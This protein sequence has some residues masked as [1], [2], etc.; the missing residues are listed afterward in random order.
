M[1]ESSSA[2]GSHA[3]YDPEKARSDVRQ[4]FSD[5]LRVGNEI[6]R[7]AANLLLRAFQSSEANLVDIVAIGH[8]YRSLIVAADGCLLCLEAGAAEQALVHTRGAFEASLQLQWLLKVDRETRA[9]RFYVGHL[10]EERSWHLR[11][12]SGT[13]EH[14]EHKKVWEAAGDSGPP[15]DPEENRVLVDRTNAELATDA[16]REVNEWFDTAKQRGGRSFE[17]KWYSVGP[18]GQRNLSS[19]ATE[20]GRRTDYRTIYKY[21]SYAVHSS[22]LT[23]SVGVR[24]SKMTIEHI[25]IPRHFSS[26]FSFAFTELLSRSLEIASI[27]RPDDVPQFVSRAHT[28]WLPT[29]SRWV[30]VKLSNASE[31]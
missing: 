13:A 11:A 27:Y 30:D 16:Y 7:E 17:P 2:L 22:S 31:N 29:V 14:D 28:E 18:G 23:A 19:V 10:R 25:R 20:L 4:H 8:F 1:F 9:K 21:L 3:L 12:I 26:G 15:L 5:Q 6:V 24:S